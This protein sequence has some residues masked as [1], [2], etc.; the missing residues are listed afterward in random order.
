MYASIRN[1]RSSDARELA[2]RAGEG[3]LPL[4]QDVEGFA[5]YYI[6]DAGDGRVASITVCQ[7]QA[8]VEESVN[9][10]RDWVAENAS[11]LVEG[12]PEVLNG[13]VTVDSSAQART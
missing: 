10:S 13:E 12:A 2:R 9:R 7:D 6:V 1:Y 3:F 4:L 11:E 8:G 5:G